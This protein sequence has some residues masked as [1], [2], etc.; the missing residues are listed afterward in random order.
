MKPVAEKT[1]EN[2]IEPAVTSLAPLKYL[3]IVTE[4]KHAGSYT[5]NTFPGAVGVFGYVKKCV[6]PAL[7]YYIGLQY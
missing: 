1:T 7:E 4:A 3:L 6:P 2:A 5:G